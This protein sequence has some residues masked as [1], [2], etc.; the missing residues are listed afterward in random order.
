MFRTL[1]I[2]VVLMALAPPAGSAPVTPAAV[3]PAPQGPAP[4]S[5]PLPQLDTWRMP[6]GSAEGWTVGDHVRVTRA[7]KPVGEGVVLT[8]APHACDVVF[9]RMSQKPQRGDMVEFVRHRTALPKDPPRSSVHMPGT[10]SV[11][12]AGSGQSPTDWKPLGKVEGLLG[13]DWM[14]RN[15]RYAHVYARKGDITYLREV[16]E[17]LDASYEVN[18]QF[19]GVAPRVPMTFYF[20]PL[21]NPAH[22]QPRFQQRLRNRT[23]IAGVALS[24]LDVVCMNLGNWRTSSHHEPWEVEKTC[25]HEMNHIFAFGV[26]GTDRMRSWE[27]LAEALAHTIEDTVNPVSSRLTPEIIKTYMQG[28]R[29]RDTSWSSLIGDRNDD[30]LEQYREYSKLLM[31]VIYFLQ[32]K[33]GRD[34]I[35]R[36]MV[37]SR[38]RDIEDAFVQV[39]G[40]G[41]RDLEAEWKACYGIR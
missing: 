31:S 22:T 36:I 28:Y 41:S 25:R 16:V 5:A 37:A 38:G 10:S 34:V 30:E 26:R 33:Y 29:S 8:A 27:W 15:T 12:A 32:E 21:E 1:L 13:D 7:G 18:L 2:L 4:L 39:T 6:A 3:T 23:R 14:E 11:P 19:M 17:M 20:F 9:T 35:S 40:K 24:G